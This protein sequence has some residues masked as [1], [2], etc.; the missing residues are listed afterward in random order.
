[1]KAAAYALNTTGSLETIQQQTAQDEMH[2]VV[3][4][5][6]SLGAMLNL[7]LVRVDVLHDLS[8]VDGLTDIAA[9]DEYLT[10]GA[11]V[12]HARLEDE[13]ASDT[14]LQFL[15][16]V[17]HGIAYRAVR[18]SG[19]I[20]GS[21]CHADPAADWI[22]AIALLGAQ[23]VID[24]PQGRRTVAAENFMQFAFETDLQPGEVLTRI[25]IPRYPQ[26]THW[27]YRKHCRKTGE[28]AM[29]I[30]AAIQVPDTGVCRITFGALDGPPLTLSGDSLFQKLTS[31]TGREEL[32]SSLTGHIAADQIVLHRDLL[33]QVASDLGAFK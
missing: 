6:Q 8:V 3:A 11:M 5:G 15:S 20:G 23:L 29:A 10:V 25:R 27:S 9:D 13:P 28:F 33:R 18:N 12:T 17:A 32:L 7:R 19:T 14:T 24:G 4:G 2:K 30:V 21:L 26:A 22:S 16:H 31:E 1:M